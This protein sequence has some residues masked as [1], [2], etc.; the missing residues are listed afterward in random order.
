MT[1]PKQGSGEEYVK[2]VI[3]FLEGIRDEKRKK[4]KGGRM[5]MEWNVSARIFQPR[6]KKEEQKK[7]KRRDEGE[8]MKL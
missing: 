2:R 6:E 5:Q 3:E 4:E 7:H 8:I 1:I